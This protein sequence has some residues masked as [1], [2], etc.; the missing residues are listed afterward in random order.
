SKID[1]FGPAVIRTALFVK[2]M[3]SIPDNKRAIERLPSDQ[4][5]TV[6]PSGTFTGGAVVLDGWRNP[7]VFVP[8]TG[9][10]GVKSKQ[11]DTFSATNYSR[12]ARV[13]QGGEYWT[14]IDS[15]SS[16]PAPPSW[17][18]GIRSPDGRALWASAGPDGN[19]TTGDDNIYS[20]EQ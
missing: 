11:A 5:L 17:F 13:I 16:A 2:Y 19:F 10:A 8:A 3:S 12:G 6:P 1:R 7:I 14:A 20:F 18:N 4:M 15:T 9:L